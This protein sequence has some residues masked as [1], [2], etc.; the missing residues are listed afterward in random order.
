MNSQL[1]KGFVDTF[2][3]KGDDGTEGD[4]NIPT[5]N[6]RCITPADPGFYRPVD[7]VCIFNVRRTLIVVSWI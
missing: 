4:F 2:S 1:L 5:K 7:M 3:V 6:L